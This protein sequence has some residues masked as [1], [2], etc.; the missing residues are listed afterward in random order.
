MLQESKPTTGH[1]TVQSRNTEQNFT[2]Q[3]N[4]RRTIKPTQYPQSSQLFTALE[5]FSFSLVP[6]NS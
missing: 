1:E 3:R 5:D 4:Y 6:F 2:L